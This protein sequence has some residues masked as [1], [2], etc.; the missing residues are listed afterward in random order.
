MFQK[1]TAVGL[2]KPRLRCSV[3]SAVVLVIVNAGHSPGGISQPSNKS[4]NAK[5]ESAPLSTSSYLIL[6]T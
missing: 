6:S 4:H 2:E 1:K 5:P 3:S